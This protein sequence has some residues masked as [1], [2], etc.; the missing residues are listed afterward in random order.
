MLE[1]NTRVLFGAD[2]IAHFST[3]AVIALCI[4]I[5]LISVTSRTHRL[6]GLSFIWFILVLIGIVE[7]YRQFLL[8]DRTAELWDAVANILGVST[9][10]VLPLLFSINKEALPVARYF[11]IFFIILFPLFLGLA[12]INERH[13]IVDP[14]EIN[15]VD[16]GSGH[17][18]SRGVRPFVPVGH[19]DGV[20]IPVNGADTSNMGH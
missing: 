8:P 5:V 7:E 12:E 18:G 6:R 13:I 1:F 9:G 14:G 19:E 10:M 20:F 17:G 3:Y 2:K 15:H 4:G 11:V 16:S